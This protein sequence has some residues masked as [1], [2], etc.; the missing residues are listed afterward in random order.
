MNSSDAPV[1]GSV[2][3]VVGEEVVVEFPED[4]QRDA[5]VR[6]R[7]VVVRLSE[8]G[9]K[10][11]QI[12]VLAEQLVRQFVALYKRL[13]LLQQTQPFWRHIGLIH[14]VCLPHS[15]GNVDQIPGTDLYTLRNVACAYH[16]AGEIAALKS[17]DRHVQR[18]LQRRVDTL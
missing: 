4:V 5:S 17:A 2:E 18:S 11:V 1:G 9:V 7:H 12:Q 14:S 16:N 6:S 15:G 3:A 8:H 10:L 13:Q